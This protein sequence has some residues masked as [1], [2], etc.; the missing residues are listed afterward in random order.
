MGVKP[1]L[2]SPWERSATGC[3]EPEE[4]DQRGLLAD[5]AEDGCRH[6]QVRVRAGQVLERL[7]VGRLDKEK[8]FMSIVVEFAALH[9]FGDGVKVCEHRGHGG[10][11]AVCRLSVGSHPGTRFHKSRKIFVP[12]I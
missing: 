6:R 9:D 2:S 11:L 12:C 1:P 10:P 7:P 8:R 5:A 4:L 3:D